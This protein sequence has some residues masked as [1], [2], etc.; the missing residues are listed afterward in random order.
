MVEL[1]RA[2]AWPTVIG[3]ATVVRD[4]SDHCVVEK[5][6]SARANVK[7]DCRVVEMACVQGSR[8]ATRAFWAPDQPPGSS[9]SGPRRRCDARGYFAAGASAAAR[10]QMA[11]SKESASAAAEAEMM[12]VSEPIVDHSRSPSMESMITRVRAAVAA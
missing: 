7:V 9:M 12:F 3:Q 2:S 10:F 6:R 1:D 5:L 11:Y 4:N 8:P